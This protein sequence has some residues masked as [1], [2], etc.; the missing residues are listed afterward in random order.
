ML[1]RIALTLLIVLVMAVILA[2]SLHV[3]YMRGYGSGDLLW[4]Q[5][6]AYLFV[7]VTHFGYRMTYLGLAGAMVKAIFP[8]GVTTPTE[9]HFSLVVL[10]I[11]PTSLKRYTADN[12]EISFIEPFDGVLYTGNM[13]PG[14]TLMKWSGTS[15][16]PVSP[17]EAKRYYANASKLPSGPSFDNIGG[18]S[19]RTAAGEVLRRSPTDY[20]EKDAKVTL[21]LDG[22][23]MTF[24]MNSGYI[25]YQASVDLLRPGKPAERIW[26]FNERPHM[27]SRAEYQR[28]FGHH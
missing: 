2:A 27:I 23:E 22:E 6:E 5:T 28:L 9:K 4:N 7:P 11:T 16:E 14:G 12:I 26:Q 3:Y 20:V 1:K 8:Y 21:S 19:M 10:R 24:V 18:W 17:D 15:F 25:S 13:L